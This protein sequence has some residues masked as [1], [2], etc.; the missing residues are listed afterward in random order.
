MVKLD[1]RA[2]I[3][4]KQHDQLRLPSSFPATQHPTLVYLN[5]AV[6]AYLPRQA[7]G[8]ERQVFGKHHFR[9]LFSFVPGRETGSPMLNFKSSR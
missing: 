9:A 1:F 7:L 8:F 5:I 2:L 3:E 6:V 4:R